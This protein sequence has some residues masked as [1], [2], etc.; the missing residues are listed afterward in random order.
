MSA[1]SR[2]LALAVAAS[3]LAPAGLRAQRASDDETRR[4]QDSI[5]VLQSLV[6]APDDRIPQRLLDGAQAIVVIPS[7]IKGGF[8]LGAKHGTG[9]I[10][11]RDPTADTWS[12]PV[13]VT[14]TG[15]SIGWQIGVESIDLALLVMNRDSIDKLLQ[16]KFTLGGNL[17]VAAGPVGRSGDAATDAQVSAQILAYSRAQGLFAGATFEGATIH[18]DDSA[19]RAFYGQTISLRNLIS[20]APERGRTLPEAAVTWQQTLQRL[21]GNP[22]RPGAG[23]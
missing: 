18:A 17:S 9:V 4:I 8:V 1:N 21:T 11:V 6:S 14:M 5:Q 20:A 22:L 13:F 15:G 23:R 19:N 2:V 3:L 12:P 10:S 16:D 7:L